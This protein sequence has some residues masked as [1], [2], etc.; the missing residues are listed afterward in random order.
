MLSRGN[1]V[2]WCDMV[3]SYVAVSPEMLEELDFAQGALGEDLFT[4]DICDLLDCDAFVRL[5]VDRRAVLIERRGFIS[6]QSFQ[7]LHSDTSVASVPLFQGM[8]HRI[9]AIPRSRLKSPLPF[10]SSPLPPPPL[11]PFAMS[12]PLCLC[13]CLWSLFVQ[14][15]KGLRT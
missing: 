12:L 5:V 15:V 14:H 2:I 3:M 1:M 6:I 9:P 4:K 13:L 10:P 8:R 11:F 7:F